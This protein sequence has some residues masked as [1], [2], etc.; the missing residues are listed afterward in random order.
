MST[1]IAYRTKSPAVK[2]NVAGNTVPEPPHHSPTPVVIDPPGNTKE[3]SAFTGL[4]GARLKLSDS[5][6]A[7]KMLKIFFFTLKPPAI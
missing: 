6:K 3:P 7:N 5:T 2:L 1:F 4:A